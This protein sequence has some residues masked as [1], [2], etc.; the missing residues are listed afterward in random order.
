[1]TTRKSSSHQVSG[2]FYEKIGPFHGQASVAF[3]PWGPEN[4]TAI[5]GNSECPAFEM[6]TKTGI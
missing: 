6:V 5:A 3:L 2:L 4:A 1:M